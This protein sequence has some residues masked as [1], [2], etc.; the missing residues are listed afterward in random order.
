MNLECG[1]LIGLGLEFFIRGEHRDIALHQ[2]LPALVLARH[3]RT[4]GGL[5]AEEE[6]YV[7]Q[8][9]REIVEE[10][11]EKQEK[12]AQA[13]EKQAASLEAA[14]SSAPSKK[15]RIIGVPARDRADEY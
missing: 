1:R 11:A 13:A 7:Y 6:E 9:T 2:F 8:A 3:D 4:L 12:Q 15:V 14:A 10:V 5:T